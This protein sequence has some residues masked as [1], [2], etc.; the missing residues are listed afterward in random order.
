LV[1]GPSVAMIAAPGLADQR[2]PFSDGWTPSAVMKRG[3][4]GCSRTR[5]VGGTLADRA[6]PRDTG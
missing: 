2:V 3:M 4:G 6:L 5:Y 1:N